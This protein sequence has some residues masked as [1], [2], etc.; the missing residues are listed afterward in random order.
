MV[1]TPVINHETKE[2][3]F[4]LVFSG[5]P[6]SGKTSNV[7]YV[8]REL[9]ET[10]RD[11]LISLNASADR[12]LFFDYLPMSLMVMNGIG[13]SLSSIRCLDKW[14]TMLLASWFY[15]SLMAWCL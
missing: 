1:S 4:K 3:Q 14:F 7:A 13:P 11:N 12:T 2:A 8:H 9:N 10:Q 15:G 5:P 6:M